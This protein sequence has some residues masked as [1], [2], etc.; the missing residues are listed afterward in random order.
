MTKA[1]PCP[2]T[3]AVDAH[4]AGTIS[5][6]DELA[7]RRHLL[8]GCPT[9][10]SRYTRRA[11]LSKVLAK[12]SPSALSPEDRIAIGLGFSPRP[13]RTRWGAF[14]GLVAAAAALALVVWGRPQ[15]AGFQAR[16]GVDPKAAAGELV[17]FRMRPGA[18]SEP[19]AARIAAGDELGFAYRNTT[20]SRYLFIYG[21]D[22]HGRV[23]WFSPAW[24]DARQAPP[25]PA[26]AQ[27]AGLHEIEDAVRH[28]Y[29]G[30]HL[31]IHALFSNRAWRVQEI[32][33]EV[34]RARAAGSAPAFS[35]G[36][37]VERRFEI[38]P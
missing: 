33:A 9:C 14:V 23:Y 29:E 16:G 2:H 30:R 6:G 3:A 28:H 10:H 8:D 35:D 11:L 22:E 7:M 12:A 26:A 21:V 18:A 32:E 25:A 38:G 4:F 27:A 20:A 24:T 36:V 17:V 37:E 5:P 13:R 31:E 1:S 15:D 34:T 19:L